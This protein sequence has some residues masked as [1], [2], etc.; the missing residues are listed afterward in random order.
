MSISKQCKLLDIPRSGYYRPPAQTKPQDELVMRAIDRIALEEPTFGVERTV[1]ALEKQGFT[2]KHHRVRRLMREMGLEPIYPK[3]R[4]SLPGKG[5]KVYPYLLRDLQINRSDQVWCTDITYI[6][7][8][9]SHVYLCAVMDWYSRRII[10]W[11][12][13]NTL[14]AEFCIEALEEAIALEGCPEIFNTDQGCQFTCEAWLNV[15]KKNDIKISMDG[16]GRALDNRMIERFWRSVKYDDI[17]IRAYETMPQL[18]AGLR[19]FIGKYNHRK[20]S[21]LG[22]SPEA[23]YQQSKSPPLAA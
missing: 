13:S 12:L 3:P 6:P 15:L 16:K 9:G 7:L 2:D 23:C 18:R 17:Y 11:R 14:D 4:L 21:T 20:H 19:R 5:H 22:M 10:S 1:D 8:A